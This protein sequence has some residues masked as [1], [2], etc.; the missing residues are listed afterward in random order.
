MCHQF[1]KPVKGFLIKAFPAEEVETLAKPVSIPR[2]TLIAATKPLAWVADKLI[3]FHRPL[4]PTIA[5]FSTIC[6]F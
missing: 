5:A 2:F 4:T 3:V 6:H 1:I